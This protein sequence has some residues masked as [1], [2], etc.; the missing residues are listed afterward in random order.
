[1]AQG[2]NCG[3]SKSTGQEQAAPTGPKAE[4]NVTAAPGMGG[5]QSSDGAKSQIASAHVPP[6]GQEDCACC[7]REPVKS[8]QQEKAVSPVTS[9][10]AQATPPAASPIT[11]KPAP[12]AGLKPPAPAPATQ[13]EPVAQRSGDEANARMTL[14]QGVPA[15]NP[16]G[17]TN[18]GQAVQA[19]PSQGAVSAGQPAGGWKQVPAAQ[20]G[21]VQAQQPAAQT[22]TAPYAR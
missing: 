11:A 6:P 19:Q 8:A 12:N 16:P 9:A 5:A 18:S 2:I 15:S 17:H 7:D 1:M 20:G 22:Q 13:V 10:P 3:P 4:S 14:R 21:P